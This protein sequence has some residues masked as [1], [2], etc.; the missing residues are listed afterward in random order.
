MADFS[1]LDA[2]GTLLFVEET[3]LKRRE[4]E[5]HDLELALRWA[6]LHADDPKEWPEHRQHRGMPHLVT[7]GGA[8]TPRVQD[9]SIAELAISRQAHHLATRWL[10]A[11]ALDLRHRLPLCWAALHT[12]RA[13]VWLA[14]RIAR[15]TRD[16]SPSEA[17][18]V[19]AALAAALTGEQPAR[20]LDLLEAKVIE[21]NP[22]AHADK[23]SAERARRYVS[24]GR[25]DE[26]GLRHVIAR[27]EHGDAVWVDAMIDRIAAILAAQDEAAGRTDRDRDRL[28]S[29][30]FGW[31]ARPAELLRLLLENQGDLGG[32][33]GDEG[34]KGET[35][36]DDAKPAGSDSEGDG[37]GAEDGDSK[38]A[39]G[40]T[41]ADSAPGSEGDDAGHGDQHS[42]PDLLRG[43]NERL[44]E[45]LR[46][47]DLTKTRPRAVVYVHLHAAALAGVGNGVARV[48]AGGGPRLFE[49]LAELL[50]NAQVKVSPVI[51][52]NKKVALN[53]YETPQWLR[54]RIHLIS[55]RDAFPHATT[56]S[57]NVDIDHPVPF[58]HGQLGKDAPPGQSGTHNC[59][60]LGRFH[61]RA[62]THLR[63]QVRQPGPGTHVWRTPNNLFRLVDTNGTHRLDEAIGDALIEGTSVEKGF[64][65][66]VAEHANRV[67]V[68]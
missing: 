9:L 34:D 27:V 54:E 57:R 59:A 10:L 3:L 63:Y 7:V 4:C 32:D 55:P 45:L 43:I 25:V 17:A 50:G 58:Q 15:A 19:D 40:S 31:L 36:V 11:D 47:A 65:L 12:G 39:S 33:K 26:A 49:H 16:L 23:I 20:V 29:D 53:A 41:H 56:I 14:R 46:S 2:G 6:D 67:P 13:E 38:S 48:E 60:P 44:L 42:A 8:G 1:D 22:K 35:P 5:V 61:H 62:K 24:V 66:T 28:R 30:A 51:D 52:L 21:A 64:A 68:I 37:D 18:Y